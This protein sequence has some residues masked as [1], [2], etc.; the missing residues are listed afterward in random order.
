MEIV[1]ILDTSHLDADRVTFVLCLKQEQ[2][3]TGF[4]Q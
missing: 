1:V 2:Y 3:P 4:N